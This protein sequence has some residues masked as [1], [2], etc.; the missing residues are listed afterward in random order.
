MAESFNKARKELPRQCGG[1]HKPSG[2]LPYAL[3]N[4]IE[5]VMK[6]A[7]DAPG[8]PKEDTL[9]SFGFGLTY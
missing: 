9:F 8:Y 3:A 1:K 2:K 7:P 6:Q 4:S 5:A